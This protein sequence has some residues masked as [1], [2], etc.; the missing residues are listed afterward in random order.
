MST[1]LVPL[2]EAFAG[3]DVVVIGEAMLDTYLEGA[4]G[5]FAQEAPVPVVALSGRK[6]VPGGAANTAVNARS[7]GAR[8][9]FLS[10]IGADPEAE[11]LRQALRERDVSAED[12]LA[13]PSR[14]TL[15]KQRVSAAGQTLLRLDQGSTGPVDAEAEGWLIER[16][17]ALFPRCD[18]AISHRQFY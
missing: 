18:A 8:V 15:T 11:L 6:D 12:V 1:S 10:V 16:L 9:S 5:R 13:R 4:T 7:L 3:L 2:V 14:R 17:A